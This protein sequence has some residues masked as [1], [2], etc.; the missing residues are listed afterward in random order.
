MSVGFC[1]EVIGWKLLLV[2]SRPDRSCAGVVVLR[3]MDP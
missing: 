3:V 1:S 2:G